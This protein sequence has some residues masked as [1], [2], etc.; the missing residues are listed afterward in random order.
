MGKR[1]CG[2]GDRVRNKCICGKSGVLSNE[3][4]VVNGVLDKYNGGLSKFLLGQGV[5]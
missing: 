3:F 5:G 4:L 1:Q 2:E